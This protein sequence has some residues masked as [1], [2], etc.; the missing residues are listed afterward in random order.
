VVFLLCLRPHIAWL[1]VSDEFPQYSEDLLLFL[2]TVAHDVWYIYTKE[3]VSV[4]PAP[5]TG[6]EGRD[7]GGMSRGGSCGPPSNS[8]R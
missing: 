4:L 5:D 7:K 6:S 1:Q 3:T 8:G 2:G